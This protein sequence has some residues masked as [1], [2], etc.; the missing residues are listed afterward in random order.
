MGFEPELVD[1]LNLE[2]FSFALHFLFGPAVSGCAVRGA[3]TF[4]MTKDV[5]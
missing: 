2:V 4:K 1:V 3:S 5:D